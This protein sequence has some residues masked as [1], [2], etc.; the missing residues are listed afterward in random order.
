MADSENSELIKISIKTPKEKKDVEISGKGTVKELREKV[1]EKFAS[2]PEKVVLIFAG[3]ILK[4]NESVETHKLKDG[5][6]IHLVIK[7]LPQ[8]Q[9]STSGQSATSSQ[10]SAST[11]TA[12]ESRPN[13]PPRMPG[14]NS[15]NLMDM[16]QQMQ[17]EMMRNPDLM[18]QIM[19]N[20]MVENMLSNPEVMGQ[21]MRANPQMQALIEQNPEVGHLLNN[22]ELMRQAL[23]YTRNPAM[24]Q[25]V[26]R[27]QD[28]ALSNLESIPGGYNA[29]RRMY[30]DVQEP[31]L[32]AAQEQFGGNPFASLIQ[33][34]NNSSGDN[35][36]QR[37]VENTEPLPNPWGGSGTRSTAA[38][39]TTPTTG[40]ST[41]TSSSAAPGVGGIQNMMQDMMQ[42]PSAMQNLM[43]SPYMQSAMNM[44]AQNPQMTAAAMQN[45]PM[46]ANNPQLQSMIPTMIQQMQN[47]EFQAAMQNPRVLQAMT[48]IQQGMDVLSREAP[49][50]LSGMTSMPMMPRAQ[51]TSTPSSTTST[52]PSQQ[53]TNPLASDP[54]AL[55]R[56][57][58]SLAATN[59]SAN[60]QPPEERFRTELEQ[61]TAMGFMNREANIQAL[62]ATGG[63]VNAAI[64]RLLSR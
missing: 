18:Q 53:S 50:L 4:D 9:S 38:T 43:S 33:N 52:T 56:I 28:R 51:T 31:M 49:Q 22:P 5:Q 63:N 59:P 27:N 42:N 58:M 61:L 57:M 41:N 35:N 17:Q 40:S 45:N 6:T 23:E 15:T 30:T 64:E 13:Q 55:S 12:T 1:A 7:S 20:P 8:A 16:Q 29:L 32:N 2:S 46:I 10:S 48:Q 14:F 60:T 19:G 54:E 47:P 25:E 44:M 36:A 34:S 37:G 62:I 26:M 11:A 39:T 3:K 21:L 24:L